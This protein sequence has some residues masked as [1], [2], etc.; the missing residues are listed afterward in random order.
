MSPLK[1]CFILEQDKGFEQ[2]E[3]KNRHSSLPDVTKGC[4]R[5]FEEEPN[6]QCRELH[7]YHRHV[8]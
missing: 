5:S 4:G 3:E 6:C 1:Y 2:G 7:D 8:F